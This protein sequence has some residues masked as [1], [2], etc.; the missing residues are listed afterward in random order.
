M[1]DQNLALNYADSVNQQVCDE[2]SSDLRALTDA[3]G[4]LPN[5][6]AQ[7]FAEFSVELKVAAAETRDLIAE[8][9]A[10]TS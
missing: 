6:F 5:G 7:E 3:S 9:E 10:L 4:T 1:P 2:F 8:I